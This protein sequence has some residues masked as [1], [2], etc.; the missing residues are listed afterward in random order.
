MYDLKITQK[1]LNNLIN[2]LSAD[3]LSLTKNILSLH[4][5]ADEYFEKSNYEYEYDGVLRAIEHKT[6]LL[7][8]SGIQLLELLELN[9]EYHN[10][11]DRMEL[12]IIKKEAVNNDLYIFIIFG[13]ESNRKESK[14][15]KNSTCNAIKMGV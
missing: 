11:Y 7:K 12:S 8:Y 13:G 3:V 15:K 1:N 5:E 2:V 9:K 4:E 6:Q 10:P 14:S